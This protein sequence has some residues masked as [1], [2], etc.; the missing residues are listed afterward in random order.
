[1]RRLGILLGI[2]VFVFSAANAQAKQKNRIQVQ[3]QI[4]R[5]AGNLP[6]KTFVDEKIWTTDD[7]PEKLKNKVLVFSRGWF[8]LGKDRLKFDK[9]RCFWNETEIPIGDPKELNL[10]E[11][12]IEWVASPEIA[13]YE[14]AAGSFKIEPKQPI[15]YFEK[16]ADGLFEL[17]EMELQTG[18][19]IVITEAIEEAKDGYIAL[20]D[21]V[22]S[23]RSV[24]RREKIEGV[25]LAVG[26]PILGQEKYVF[27]FR[28]RPGKD[29][30]I[31]I[32]PESERGGLLLRL[33]ASSTHSGTLPENNQAG[34]RKE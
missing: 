2:I 25:N 32:R 11:D 29:Y 19:D 1:M 5:L 33:R 24:E 28:L 15:Q 22:M 9:G 12:Q 3:V 31:L 4:F 27:Y 20:T 30:G 17:K 8:E 18:L 13:M 16:R 23:M 26:R 10:P 6:G 21:I 14:H 7:V 34:K